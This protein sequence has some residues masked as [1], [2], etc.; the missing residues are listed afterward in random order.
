MPVGG[1]PNIWRFPIEPL[2]GGPVARMQIVDGTNSSFDRAS[3][4]SLSEPVAR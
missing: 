1:A 4:V 2:G 3:R